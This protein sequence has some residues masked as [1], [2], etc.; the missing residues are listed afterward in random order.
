MCQCGKTAC[1]K[2]EGWS[3]S[4]AAQVPLRSL[5]NLWLFVLFPDYSFQAKMSEDK[6]VLGG[7]RRIRHDLWWCLRKKACLLTS[8][9]PQDAGAEGLQSLQIG[10]TNLI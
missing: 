1:Q 7:A 8:M 4:L 10:L 2:R 9:Q 6:G 5:C 3:T